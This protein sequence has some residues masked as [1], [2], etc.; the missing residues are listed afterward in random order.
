MEKREGPDWHKDTNLVE[1][2]VKAF[3]ETLQVEKDH[4]PPCLHTHFDS[5]DV[6]ADLTS[7]ELW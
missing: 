1:S 4:C 6:P 2:V 5:V 7:K 3:I